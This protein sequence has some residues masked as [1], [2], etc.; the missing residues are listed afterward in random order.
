MHTM[1]IQEQTHSHTPTSIAKWCTELLLEPDPPWGEFCSLS[2]S[3]TIESKLQAFQF[4][5][6]H[7][8]SPYKKKLFLMNLVE[9][10]TCDYCEATETIT[11]IFVECPTTLDF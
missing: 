2:F 1:L 8:F 6:L 9:S 10:E 5:V 4:S 3:C 11:H 7:R